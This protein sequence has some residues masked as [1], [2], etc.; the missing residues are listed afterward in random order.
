MRWLIVA[1]IL[2]GACGAAATPASGIRGTIVAGPACPGPAR[3]D[4][5]CPDRPVALSVEVV[6]GT[7]VVATFTIRRQP[8]DRYPRPRSS[9][10]H[11][12]R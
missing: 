11:R 4:S 5:P 10:L 1:A 8:V 3:V 7:T 12:A 6:Q 9:P 2:L